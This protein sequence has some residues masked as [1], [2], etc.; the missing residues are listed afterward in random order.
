VDGPSIIRLG[1]A[2]RS[3]DRIAGGLVLGLGVA[4][5]LAISGTTIAVANEN[6][7]LGLISGGIV[8]LG[9]VITGLILVGLRDYESIDVSPLATGA[10][11]ALLRF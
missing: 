10:T 7:A 6:P 3:A 4:T 1:L 5:A 9:S 2:D 8:F 11:D